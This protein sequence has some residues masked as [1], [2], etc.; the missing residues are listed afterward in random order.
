MKRFLLASC[1]GAA[2][3]AS[4]SAQQFSIYVDLSDPL[5]APAGPSSALGAAAGTPGVWNNIDANQQVGGVLT[6]GPL[7]DTNMVATPV[8][9]R[10]DGGGADLTTFFFDNPTTAGDDQE[11]LD[12]ISYFNG[13][14]S[15]IF[16][17]VPPGSYTVYT[18]AMAPDDSTF[19]TQVDVLGS[20]SGSQVVGGDFAG[21]YQQGIT[22]AMHDVT[23]GAG[24]TITI[25]TDV[26]S[27]FDSVA[28]F[29]IVPG[30]APGG[31]GMNYCMAAPNST[32]MPGVISA[33]GSLVASSNNVTL[34]AAG[35]PPN[36]FGI[37]IISQ[38]Q[39]FIP[40]P[41]GSDGNLCLGGV[42]GRIL[43]IQNSGAAGEYW[44]ALDLTL[45]PQGGGFVAATA[46]ESWNCSSWHRDISPGGSNFTDAINF[47]FQ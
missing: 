10:T 22:H 17:N 44:L 32:G 31:I 2:L 21:G 36:Q 30:G 41:G 9:L 15:W 26:A 11:L 16:E 25:T 8:T 43:Q 27:G 19:L 46:G 5:S 12:D 28:G 1:L 13:P 6:T 23:V 7:M 39:A 34:H 33:T 18:F 29:Q 37:F 45:I 14:G 42:I 47:I 3:S 20:A 35:L 38:T 40:N 24:G 4:A